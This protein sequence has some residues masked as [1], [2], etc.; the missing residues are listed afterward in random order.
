MSQKVLWAPWRMEYLRPEEKGGACV[1]CALP[2]QEDPREALILEKGKTVYTVL[3]K[4]P[5][6]RGHLMIIPF[7]HK[8]SLGA[9]SESSR[10]ALMD[11]AA[12]A[13][14]VLQR[15]FNPDGFNLGLNQGRAAGAGIPEHLH[16]HIVPRWNGDTNFMPVLSETKSLP[17]HLMATYDAIKE[18]FHKKD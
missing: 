1:F 18:N 9:L 4:Y 10:H 3:N 16:L 11:A 7:E 13:L 12:R 17:Q 2:G 8:A 6:N 15:T 14:D 5:Y